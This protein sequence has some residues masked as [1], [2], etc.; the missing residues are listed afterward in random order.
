MAKKSASSK[1]TSKPAPKKKPAAK[2]KAA[3]TSAAQTA[4]EEALEKLNRQQS[5]NTKFQSVILFAC[6][7]LFFL[8]AF[9]HGNAGWYFMHRV[10]R[11]IF[12][13]SIVIVPIILLI[14]AY[15]TEKR[16][17]MSLSRRLLF[18][19]GLTVLVSSFFQI[20]FIGDIGKKGFF[21]AIGYLYTTA[22]DDAFQSGGVISAVLAYPFLRI[23]GTPGA[24]IIIALLLF[25]AIMWMLDMS[26]QQLWYY[27]CWPF[28]KLRE[29]WNK[30]PDWADDIPDT[31]I[32]GEPELPQ[33]EEPEFLLPEQTGPKR[34]KVHRKGSRPAE[35]V[36]EPAA[37]DSLESAIP[38]FV[39]DNSPLSPDLDA[40]IRDNYS[41]PQDNAPYTPAYDMDIDIPIPEDEPD[42]G[43][44]VSPEELM[45][46]PPELFTPDTETAPAETAAPAAP[47]SEPVSQPPARPYQIPSID[48][49]Q[50]GVSRAEDPAVDQE[51]KEKA[52]ILVETLKSFGVTVRIT[53][54][55]RG[56]SV[57]RY[58]IQPA[59]GI[60]VSKITGL[61]DDIA[62]SLAAQGVRI[63]APIPGKPAIGIEVPNS[64]KDTVSLREILESDSFRSSRSKLAFAVGRDIAGNAVVG[65][66]ARL[67]HMIIA[68]ATGSGKSVCT[69]S[70]IMSILY[71]ATPEEV[72][73]ILIDPKIV[74]FTVYEGI[75]HLLIPV[76]T[77]PKKA[78]GA[79]NWAVQEM[80]RRYNLFAENSVRD[81][82]DYNAAAAQPGSGLEP[83][84]QIVVIIDEL[85]DLMMTTS[86]EVEDSICR[87]AQKARAAGMH[88]IIATQRPTTDII[89]GLIKANI[90]SRIALSVM[91]QVDSR[92]ILD[93]GGAEKLLGHGD[94]L[95]LPNGKIKPV[96]VQGCFTSTKEIEKVVDFIKSQ[97]QSEY[98]DE[99]MEQVE[100]SIP[101][102]KAEAKELRAAEK[103]AAVNEPEPGSDEDVLERAIE[104][105]VEAGQASTSSLQRRLKLGYAR[106]ARMMDELEQ[107]GV[108]GPYEG[109]KPRKVLMTKEQLAER[110][111]RRLQ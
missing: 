79:L 7:V 5:G 100:Q 66:I 56:P 36:P 82:G 99:I 87:L 90:P 110:K 111:M 88:L 35:P 62:L 95:Y 58:E 83:M 27:I 103:A 63:E 4:K 70:I 107:M 85:A 69:N 34:A 76:V 24:Q 15:Y 21:R 75:P 9:I 39:E 98:S 8:L 59:A 12:G 49:L 11:G 108:I 16:E 42:N 52:G 105:V 55:F 40:M 37:D 74:E 94:M 10:I 60:K 53:G 96:R 32:S 68:G 101:V 92:T 50:N 17:G 84:P 2:K 6:A 43:A 65:D 93:T 57:T 28:R 97:T 86:K 106:A 61:A 31:D 80:Q 102:T 29:L 104:V 38:D 19:A 3:G 18:S 51:M 91:S 1:K 45:Q 47:A 89:T 13:F 20:M 81:L 26:M 48:F 72:K 64:H 41:Q 22:A 25:V 71:H 73:L 23:I 14:T 67:P 44:I 77:D 78:A 109:A 46:D 54:I 33:A 30:E